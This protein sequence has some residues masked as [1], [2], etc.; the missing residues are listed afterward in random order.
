MQPIHRR[1]DG[2]HGAVH[3]GGFVCL[4]LPFEQVGAQ[5]ESQKVARVEAQRPLQRVLFSLL[6][7]Q[8]SAGKRQVDPLLRVFCPDRDEALERVARGL[9]VALPKGPLA[10]CRQRRGMRRRDGENPREDRHDVLV[11]TGLRGT[12]ELSFEG[13]DFPGEGI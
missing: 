8:A 10:D 12:F 4:S 9:H 1:R 2:G 11:P 6:V 5:D 7:V 13:G 3:G